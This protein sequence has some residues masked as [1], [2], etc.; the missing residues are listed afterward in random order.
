[1]DWQRIIK[2]AERIVHDMG[3]KKTDLAEILGVTPQFIADVKSEKS[4][5]PR[6]SFALS[7]ITRLNFNPDWLLSGEGEM[8]NSGSEDIELENRRIITEKDIEIAELKKT[9]ADIEN[10]KARVKSL[11]AENKELEAENKQLSEDLLE[12]VRKFVIAPKATKA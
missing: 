3:K 4:K 10:Q 5:N 1:M 6:P 8:L 11:E 12:M 2:E 9:I 7:L